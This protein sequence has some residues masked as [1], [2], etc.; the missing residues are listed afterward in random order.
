MTGSDKSCDYRGCRNRRNATEA[1]ATLSN[2]GRCK[3]REPASQRA[4]QPSSLSFDLTVD[5]LL[6]VSKVLLEKL[7][8]EGLE[9]PQAHVRL[10]VARDY[11][12]YVIALE[13]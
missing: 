13:N 5:T 7:S 3:V 9:I 1:P 11:M 2:C 12:P 6:S 10:D 4:I 8:E